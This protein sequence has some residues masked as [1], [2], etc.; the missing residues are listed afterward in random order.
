ML[1][2]YLSVFASVLLTVYGQLVL[3]WRVDVAGDLPDG[4]SGRLRYL[5]DL[6]IDPWVITVIVTVIAAG[7]AWILAI[8]ELDLS[9]AYP[10]MALTFAFVLVGSSI[11]FAEPITSWKVVGVAL[12]V[13]GVVLGAQG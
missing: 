1:R 5:W 12:I 7:I 11:F 10:F 6:A 13:A 8:R 4:A 2:A 3:K 9:R